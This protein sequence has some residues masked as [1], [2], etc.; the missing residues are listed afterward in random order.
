MIKVLSKPTLYIKDDV[1][2]R[3]MLYTDLCRYEISALGCV[4]RVGGTFVVDE[5]HLL[6]QQVTAGST[7]LSTDG[8]STFLYE[9]VKAGKDPERIKFWWHSHAHMGAFWSGTDEATIERFNNMWMISMVSNK[10]GEYLA[11]LDVFD[12][13]RHTVELPMVVQYDVRTM[14]EREEVDKEIAGKVKFGWGNTISRAINPQLK[15]HPQDDDFEWPDPKIG[16]V[17]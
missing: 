4:T 9:Y 14:Q 13:L 10:R 16:F 2:R 5:L 11:R 7:D 3:L 12:P 15:G 8:V 17:V 6:D 1:Y